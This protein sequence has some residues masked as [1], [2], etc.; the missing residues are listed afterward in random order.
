MV[1]QTF[2][3]IDEVLRKESGCTT[4]RLLVGKASTQDVMPIVGWKEIKT[5][6]TYAAWVDAQLCQTL[7]KTVSKNNGKL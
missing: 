6:E 1:E 2:K 5:V 3:N 7:Q 4:D